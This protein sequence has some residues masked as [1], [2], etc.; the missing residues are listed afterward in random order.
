M[1]P[2]D[3]P[4]LVVE[5]DPFLRELLVDV[6]DLQGWQVRHCPGAVAA[7]QIAG[8]EPPALLITDYRIPGCNGLELLACLRGLEGLSALPAILLSGH[9]GEALSLPDGVLWLQKPVTPAQ[10]VMA[11]GQL[12]ARV[13]DPAG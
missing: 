5:D 9:A 13:T 2:R 12:L 11:T 10:L 8:R 3:C 4:L 1:S 7:L 6:L